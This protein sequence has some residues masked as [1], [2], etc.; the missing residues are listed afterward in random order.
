MLLLKTWTP[1][2][3]FPWSSSSRCDLDCNV[4]KRILVPAIIISR[5]L[6]TRR[7]L[8][9][10]FI[11]SK[12]HQGQISHCNNHNRSVHICYKYQPFVFLLYKHNFYIII[13]VRG[14]NFSCWSDRWTIVGELHTNYSLWWLAKL[15]GRPQYQLQLHVACY[16]IL[17]TFE[18]FNWVELSSDDKK[19]SARCSQ[20]RKKPAAAR[21]RRGSVLQFAFIVSLH[22]CGWQIVLIALHSAI[23][24]K[25]S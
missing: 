1:Q 6:I 20:P 9:S 21:S 25:W 7:R 5:E 16:D 4:I 13:A 11:L 3:F 23:S 24:L 19:N 15:S 22:M 14:L 18:Y 10:V 17:I 8:D 12:M 2:Q